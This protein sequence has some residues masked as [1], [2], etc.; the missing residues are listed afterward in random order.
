[1][2]TKEQFMKITDVKKL[3]AKLKNDVSKM[4]KNAKNVKKEAEKIV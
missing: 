1:M 2:L 3:N 4:K